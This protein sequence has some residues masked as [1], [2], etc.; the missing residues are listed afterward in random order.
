MPGQPLDE[1]VHAKLVDTINPEDFRG[2]I[3]DLFDIKFVSPDT[4]KRLM[5]RCYIK[6][7][8]GPGGA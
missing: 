5:Q 4:P 6:N 2:D 1:E 7:A 3:L 8:T